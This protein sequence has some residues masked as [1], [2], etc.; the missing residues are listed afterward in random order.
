MK[1]N[2]TAFLNLVFLFGIPTFSRGRAILNILDKWFQ[3]PDIEIAREIGVRKG[4]LSKYLNGG[5]RVTEEK[6]ARLE[7]L[8][9][10]CI[11]AGRDA[12]DSVPEGY[13]IDAANLGGMAILRAVIDASESVLEGE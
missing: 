4:T 6:E 1:A 11:K 13:Y 8:L 12:L 10:D 3:I 9:R 7:R 5:L 2:R